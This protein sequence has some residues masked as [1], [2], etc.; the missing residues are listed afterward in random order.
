MCPDGLGLPIGL[1]DAVHVADEA[2]YAGDRQAAGSGGDVF[3]VPEERPNVEQV[4]LHG[5]GRVLETRPEMVENPPVE[6]SENLCLFLHV[7]ISLSL[8][9]THTHTHV[10]K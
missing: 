4:V 9:H 6:E 10:N 8:S 1:D 3:H 5:V 2:V 7:F